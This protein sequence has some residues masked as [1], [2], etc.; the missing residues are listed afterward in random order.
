VNEEKLERGLSEKHVQLIAIGGTIGI[1]LFLASGNA[2]ALAGPS[3]LLSYLLNGIA[4]FFI[5]RALGEVSVENPIAGSF[6]AYAHKF[7]GPGAGFVTG[8]SYWFMWTVIFMAEITAVGIYCNYWWPELPQWIPALLSLMCITATNLLNVKLF[9][10]FEFWF[11]LIKVITIIIIIITGL[12][13]IF[14]GF[15][16]NPVG[17]SN[18]FVLKGGFLPF[19]TSGVLKALGVSILAFIGIEFVGITAAE[20]KNPEKTIP[21]ATKKILFTILLLYIGTLFVIMC[22]YP[23]TKLVKGNGVEQSPFVTTFLG[24]GIKQAATIIN[25]VVITAS[26]SACNSGMFSN[27]RMLYNL[28]I[29]KHA[30]KFLSK[31]NSN[32]IPANA[33]IASF[34]VAMI[35]V[36]LNFIMPKNVFIS[37][38][39]VIAFLGLWTWGAII[40]IQMRSR[41]NMDTKDILK[42]KYPMPFYPYSNYITFLILVITAVTLIMKNTTRNSFIVGPIWLILVYSIYKFFVKEKK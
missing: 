17:I 31:V 5:L 9:G 39:S 42:L 40:V 41:C 8:W 36:I 7:I 18:L 3:L 2:I 28:A 37:L 35:G 22:M 32:K 34:A 12:L 33:I 30:P 14:F 25:F 29:N 27:G 23:W 4:V 24:L 13:V 1:G 21:S 26:L 11:A 15:N 20:A 6:S 38:T 10:E 19:G 16:H